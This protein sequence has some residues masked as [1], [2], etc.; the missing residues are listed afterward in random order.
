MKS[1]FIAI[2]YIK[3]LLPYLALIALYFFFINIEAKKDK[4]LNKTLDKSYKQQDKKLKL[5]D[6]QNRVIIPVIPFK[7]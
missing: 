4:S 2:K 1:I 3:N 5:E 7:Q 6:R